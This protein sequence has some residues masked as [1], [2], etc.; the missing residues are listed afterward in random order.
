MHVNKK[1]W[2]YFFLFI[3]LNVLLYLCIAFFHNKI[4]FSSLNYTTNAYHYLS[5][6]R[7]IGGEF[8]LLRGLG[9]YDAQWYLHVASVGYPQSPHDTHMAYEKDFSGMSYAFFPLYPTILYLV[10]RVVNNIEISAFV[11]ANILLIANFIS[12][13]YFVTHIFNENTAFKTAWLLFLFPFSI[14][15]RSYFTEGLFLLLLI[16]FSYFL[17]KK[18]WLTSALFLSLLLVTRPNAVVLGLLFSVCIGLEYKRKELSL[19][20]LL[21]AILISIIPLFGWLLYCYLHTGDVFYW[22]TIQSSWYSS[23][24]ITNPLIHNLETISRFPYLDL[25]NFHSS[26]ID[27]ITLIL[28][29]ILLFFSRKKLSPELWWMC[30]LFWLIPLL[31]KDTMSFTRYQIVAFPLFIYLALQLRGMRYGIVVSLFCVGLFIVS[32]FFVNWYWIG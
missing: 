9:Q 30:L 1:F 13:Y 14:F 19:R 29:G 12:L 15:Y 2:V 31:F 3:A 7:I 8:D 24:N 27:V 25:H 21:D 26:K 16:W 6:E 28:V 10:T 17:L 20:T 18:R 4:P 22:L 32:I 5:D 23:Q 11:V